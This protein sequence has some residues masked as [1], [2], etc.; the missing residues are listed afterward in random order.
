MNIAFMAKL[1]WR[2]FTESD[3]LWENILTPKYVRGSL[4]ISKIERKKN[5]S[6]AWQG[7]VA[8]TNILKKRLRQKVYNG[9]STLFW[10][11]IWLGDL[12]LISIALHKGNLV[13][14]Y[15]W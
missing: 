4:D 1:G 8:A 2:L 15:N 10:R 9:A 6:N 14:S 13:D 3:K 5:S 12:P 11:D 7:L